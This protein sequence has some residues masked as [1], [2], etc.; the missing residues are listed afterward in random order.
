MV[1]IMHTAY[2]KITGEQVA[3]MRMKSHDYHLTYTQIERA[4]D[5]PADLLILKEGRGNLV[6]HNQRQRN[7][8]SHYHNQIP[9][10]FHNKV[11]LTT[12]S[13]FIVNDKDCYLNLFLC[14]DG[15]LYWTCETDELEAPLLHQWS[16][17]QQRVRIIYD[18]CFIDY[19]GVL[20][21]LIQKDQVILIYRLDLPFQVITISPFCG[22]SIIKSDEGLLY[23]LTQDQQCLNG[24]QL[25]RLPI[26]DQFFEVKSMIV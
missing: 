22:G 8:I 18:N 10:E 3:V 12:S 16:L 9:P 20:H 4:V 17:L 7:A 11:R 2:D 25:R 19:E 24:K 23:F 14:H 26:T 13:P 21:C 15:F 6:S 5:N 1:K